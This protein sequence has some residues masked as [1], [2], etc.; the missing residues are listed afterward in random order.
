MLSRLAKLS[1]TTLALLAFVL[2]AGV[3]IS[4]AY[5]AALVIESRTQKV[6]T[7]RLTEA[8]ITWITVATDGLQVRLTGTAP[9]EADRFRAVNMVGALI[10]TSRIRD[11]L[12][13]TPASAI[14]APK[15]SVEMLRTEDEVQLSG[16]IPENPGEGGLTEAALS[17]AAAALAQGTELPDMLETADYPAPEAWNE[18][19]AFGLQALERLELSKVSVT[20]DRVEVKA[21]TDSAEEKRR[22][23]TE[24]RGLA[25]AKVQLVLD[26]SAPRPVITPFTL[27]FVRDAEG[28]RF[29]SCSADTDRARSQILR[30]AATAGVEGSS[31]CQVGL[32][33]PTPRWAEAVG[34]GIRA[35]TELGSG[36]ITFSDADVTL[37]AGSDV[38]Q[39]TF[40]KVVGELETGLPDVFSLTSTLE[41]KATAT[42]GPAEFTATLS[43]TGRVELRGRLTDEMQRQ[44]VDAF[45]RSAFSGAQV[46]TATR[47]DETLPDG[48]PV[49]VLA[50]LKA[51]SEVEHGKLLVR[52]DLVEVT[53]VTGS[54]ATRGRITQIL[55][56]ELG[57]GQTFRVNVRY[58]EALDPL[59]ALPTPEECAADV[60]TVIART[61]IT[62]TPASAEIA[63]TARPVLDELAAILSNCPPMQMEIGGHTDSQGSE[64]G[65]QA[66]SQARAEAVLLALQGRR[67]DV[68]GMTA[69]GYGETQPIAEN[70]TESGREANRRIEFVLQGVPQAAEVPAS[71]E[72]QTAAPEAAVADAAP[73]E[74]IA[75]QTPVAAAPAEN[76]GPVAT[77][78]GPDFSAD[79]SPSVAPTEKTIAPKPRPEG[80]KAE[81]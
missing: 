56:D 12:D 2:A 19:L 30:T 50:G 69:L 31:V 52:A 24:L 81:E 44:A 61:K 41:K 14:E 17:E 39:A 66:L 18:A 37:L 48:W 70:Q 68:S 49:R 32:G 77:A 60:N 28:A 6:V 51:L 47:L 35:V 26:I 16:L 9:R 5:G 7:T 59:A 27:R 8:G 57:Q 80:L 42:Q 21:I 23:E 74:A 58:D 22:L 4:V 63:T 64:G 1:S 33:T 79:T 20:A 71:G 15:F 25:P 34:L 76:A 13:V 3:M 45:A 54:T 55:S 10:D 46:L 72:A 75:T 73:A 38:P 43:E 53:G 65:N 29:D 36:S 40:D 62:F 78:G 67:V 11:G